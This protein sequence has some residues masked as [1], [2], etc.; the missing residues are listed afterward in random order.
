MNRVQLIL[1]IK[2][3]S[4]PTM[5]SLKKIS[6]PIGHISLDLMLCREMIRPWFTLV[7]S[8]FL[9]VISIN[10]NFVNAFDW[11]SGTNGQVRWAHNCDF[12]GNDI[13]SQGSSGEDCGGL[14]V[15]NQQCTHFTHWNG[16]CYI[17]RAYYPTAVDLNGGTCGW[18]DHRSMCV[19]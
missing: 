13:A 3:K 2:L 11:Q 18:V 16:V 12:Q 17:K 7:A 10:L 8:L 9:V 4:V 1:C 5:G 14:C 19:K 6:Y 15:S